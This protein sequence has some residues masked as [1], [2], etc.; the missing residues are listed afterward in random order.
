M[1]VYMEVVSQFLLIKQSQTHNTGKG[2]YRVKWE[3][4]ER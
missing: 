3:D 2:R 1:L 4:R